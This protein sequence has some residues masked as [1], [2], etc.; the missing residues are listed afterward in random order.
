MNEALLNQSTQLI[1]LERLLGLC[2]G[3]AFIPIVA[4]QLY[5]AIPRDIDIYISDILR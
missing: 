1:R 5:H 2:I 4:S 3:L